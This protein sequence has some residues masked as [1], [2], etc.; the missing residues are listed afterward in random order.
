MIKGIKQSTTAK[1][2][3]S[4]VIGGG[5]L[6]DTGLHKVAITLAY[7]DKSRRGA[8]SMNFIFK[9]EDG[10]ELRNSIYITNRDGENFYVKGDEELLLPGWMHAAALYRAA[11]GEELDVADTEEKTINIYDYDAK[12]D[13]PQSR[14]IL[15]AMLGKT[16]ILGLHKIT[17]DKNVKNSAGKYVASGK[18][19][20]INEINKTFL[21]TGLT[22]AEA[23]EGITSPVFLTKW[24][25]TYGVKTINKS[26]GIRDESLGGSES[27]GAA[28]ETTESLFDS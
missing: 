2:E 3:E 4:D 10:K 27:G 6:W 1:N 21:P 26:T 12:K 14:E 5:F 18:T 16:V 8:T 11:T 19:R 15:T 23:E 28:A 9:R 25:E 13:L 7:L 24:K 20:D 17:E 22:N